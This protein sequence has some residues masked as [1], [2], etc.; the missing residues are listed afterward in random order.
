MQDAARAGDEQAFAQ[1]VAEHRRELLVHCYRMLGSLEDAEDALQ[2][3]LVAGWRGLSGFQQRSSLRAWR[4][5]I[6][7]NCCL[8][9]ASQRA[10]RMLSYDH[11]P[12]R[13]PGDD[14]GEPV[15]GPVAGALARPP[16]G[17]AEPAERPRS[18]LGPQGAHRACPDRTTCC[19]DTVWAAP[20]DPL[21]SVAA[22]LPRLSARGGA[23][24]CCELSR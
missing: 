14:L 1:L 2:E 6:A 16:V 13:S 18:G 8:R 21:R 19:S 17:H 24:V 9:A 23:P 15:T 20:D 12:V 11:G 7:T 22:G 4:Y 5:R 3:I 10:A